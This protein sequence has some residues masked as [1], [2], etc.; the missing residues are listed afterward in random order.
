MKK[1]IIT[2]LIL[3]IIILS[4]F[5]GILIY[6]STQEIKYGNTFYA[7][8]KYKT[9]LLENTEENKIVFIGGSSLAFGLRSEEIEKVLG[10]KVVNYGLYAAIGTKPMMDLALKDIKEG[11][12]VILAPELSKETYSLNFNYEMVNK[13]LE[14]C[15]Y[16][17]N[18]FSILDRGNLL[19]NKF[20]YIIEKANV[21]VNVQP[22]YDLA[23]F[24]EYGDIESELVKQNILYDLYDTEQL[25]I[26][27]KELA[28]IDFIECVN[29]Y[30]KKVERK[31]AK[32]YFTYSPTNRLSLEGDNISEFYD[33]L[34]KELKVKTLGTINDFVYHEDYFYDT[35]Y[36]LNYAGS[37]I[38]S[39]QLAGF[40]KDELGIESDYVIEEIEKPNPKY[41]LSQEE[42]D[43]ECF[44]FKIVDNE[45]V[46]S[47]VK[48]EY[49]GERK[50][51]VPEMIDDMPVTGI[52]S[53][54]FS[55]MPNL[56]VVILPK[57]IN[58]LANDIFIGSPNVQKLY[59][60]GET[61]P[62]FVGNGLLNG[63][64]NCNIYV[65][66]DALSSYLLGYTWSNY[67][68]QIHTYTNLE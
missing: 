18:R 33:V 21:N 37:L 6:G 56:E 57:H 60:L 8:L 19:I 25:I 49:K 4:P 14:N 26:P 41:E 34:E 27:N 23:S 13:C 7:E 66:P 2:F 28:N 61:A 46:L 22:P 52:L 31:G 11:D 68:K 15:G 51:I 9:E 36:H 16:Y 20:S 24:N 48:E 29:N 43:S 38:H 12:I 17:K 1:L 30:A 55:N 3:M 40:I 63:T 50:L 64:T 42:T 47:G 67:K 10:Y 53:S 44:I 65:N 62:S 59:L 39:K 58:Q 5:I 32:I 54:A 35:N 45:L